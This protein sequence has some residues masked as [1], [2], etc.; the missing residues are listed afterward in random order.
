MGRM[1][2]DDNYGL[3]R[4]RDDVILMQLRPR[5]AEGVG[6]QVVRGVAA[7]RG[8]I[9]GWLGEGIE[10]RLHGFREAAW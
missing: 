1:L 3:M 7:V 4:L 5:G 8:G 6:L 2:V 10:R 9:R